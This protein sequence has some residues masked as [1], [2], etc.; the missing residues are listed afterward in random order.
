MQFFSLQVSD[1][2]VETYN[3]ALA[4][5]NLI[6]HADGTFCIDNET[7]HDICDRTLKLEL[8]TYD[9]LN[10]LVS[11]VMSG[12]TTCLRY[13]GQLNADL[14]K[15][16]VNLVPYPRLHFFM[17]GSAP[18]IARGCE[19]YST[20]TV[21]ELSYQLFDPRNMMVAC[22]PRHGVYLTAAAI[23]RG[24]LSVEEVAECMAKIQNLNSGFFYK[25]IPDNIMTAVCDVPPKGLLMS[26]LVIANN[27]A[28]REIFERISKQ[29]R[30]KILKFSFVK[31]AILCNLI[32]TEHL[33]DM[34]T[35]YLV[36][37][38]INSGTLVVR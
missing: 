16:S 3:A 10:H 35:K 17:T 25:W 26:S 34:M 1:T 23:F 7:L 6:K 21:Q 14:R 19:Q 31:D 18:L 24:R 28:I 30:G 9:D 5:D 2:V 12:V 33:I 38:I 36:K 15:I 8:P 13:P 20:C 11:T 27:T 32:P 4:I 29:F 22:D 37:L